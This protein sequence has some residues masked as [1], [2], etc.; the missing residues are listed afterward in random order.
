MRSRKFAMF[1][2]ALLCSLPLFAGPKPGKW[3]GTIQME[4]PGMGKMPPMTVSHC[5]TAEDAAHPE[6][7]IPRGQNDAACKL[8]DVKMDGSTVSWNVN[9]PAQ[10]RRPATTGHGQ[11]TYGSES[12]DGW[13]KMKMQDQEMTISYKGKRV[14][15]CSK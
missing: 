1:L 2:G 10:G 6:K 15:D 9:C 13:M 11:I 14:G 4:M 12:Y 3:E 8:E 7:N 5:V